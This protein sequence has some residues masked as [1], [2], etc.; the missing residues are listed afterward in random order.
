MLDFLRQD[1]TDT[2]KYSIVKEGKCDN[3]QWLYCQNEMS[4]AF[5]VPFLEDQQDSVDYFSSYHYC[6]LI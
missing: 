4:N 2:Q 5:F 3:F 6:L 1:L